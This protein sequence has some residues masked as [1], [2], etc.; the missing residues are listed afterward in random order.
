[1]AKVT[2]KDN[3]IWLRHIEGDSRLVRRLD[4]LHPDEVIEL[5]VNGVVGRWQRMRPGRD[6]RNTH[7]IKPIDTMRQVWA[8]MQSER[9]KI[10]D[11]R[12][13]RT[14]DSYLAALTPLMSEWNSP[15]DE[16]AYR[17]L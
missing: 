15:E 12:E 9:G 4:G 10:V 8:R 5:E 17:D 11:I 6:G 1:M 14:A 2:I 3:S 13:V 16:E 7:G